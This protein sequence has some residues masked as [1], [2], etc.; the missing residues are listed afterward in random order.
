MAFGLRILDDANIL[1]DALCQAQ[2][3][4]K[5]LKLAKVKIALEQVQSPVTDREVV[6]EVLLPSTEPREDKDLQDTA[7]ERYLDCETNLAE[8]KRKCPFAYVL[9]DSNP[10]ALRADS[11]SPANLGLGIAMSPKSD[12]VCMQ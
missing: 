3:C 7:K 1:S 10:N 12:G 5:R 8:D 6:V 2:F 11:G 4:D 9:L